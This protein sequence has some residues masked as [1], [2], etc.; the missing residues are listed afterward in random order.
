MPNPL[1]RENVF[2]WLVGF[3]PRS[4]PSPSFFKDPFGLLGGFFPLGVG[5]A[6]TG[7]AAGGGRAT[8]E[9]CAAGMCCES[10]AQKEGIM[11]DHN[12]RMKRSSGIM[13]MVSSVEHPDILGERC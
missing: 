8:G 1:S 5:E 9:G 7:G 10:V 2:L 4:H 11:G 13:M 6:G 12:L 3:R